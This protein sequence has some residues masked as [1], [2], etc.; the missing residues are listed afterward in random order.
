[1][2]EARIVKP[3]SKKEITNPHFHSIMKGCKIVKRW[4]KNNSKGSHGLS[5]VGYCQTHK[6][7]I[8]HCGWEWHWHYG[9]YHPPLHDNQITYS[10]LKTKP[11]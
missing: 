6:V 7:N 5:E 11:T 8:C 1:M 2:I 3:L 4:L 9:K 10:I